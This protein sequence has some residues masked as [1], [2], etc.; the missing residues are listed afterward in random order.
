MNS[1]IDSFVEYLNYELHYSAR[2][3]HTYVEALKEYEK[4]LRKSIR[5]KQLLYI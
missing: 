1:Y 4:F 3:S 2:T 5:V